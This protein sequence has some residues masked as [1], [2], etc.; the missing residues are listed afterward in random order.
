MSFSLVIDGSFWV[1]TDV[2]MWIT[3]APIVQ[4]SL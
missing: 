3:S 4:G 1:S 2:L